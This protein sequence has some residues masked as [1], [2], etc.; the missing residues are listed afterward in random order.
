MWFTE[1]RCSATGTTNEERFQ[2]PIDVITPAII[3]N[4]QYGIGRSEIKSAPVCSSDK[5]IIC[6]SGFDFK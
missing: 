1:C 4:S 2:L 3:E 5:H 6:F